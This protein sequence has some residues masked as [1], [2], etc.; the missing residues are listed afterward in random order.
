MMNSVRAHDFVGRWG[1]DEFIAI[2]THTDSQGL[3]VVAERTRLLIEESRL[4][5]TTPPI[6]V[7]VSVGVAM[8]TRNDTEASLVQRADGLMYRSKLAGG[9]RTSR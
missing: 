2:V 8:A 7:T 1:G 9:N 3:E 5:T 4:R 6:T